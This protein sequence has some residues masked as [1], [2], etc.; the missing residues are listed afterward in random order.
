M[1]YNKPGHHKIA[2][3]IVRG[4][5]TATKTDTQESICMY[6]DEDVVKNNTVTC[7]HSCG[8]FDVWVDTPTFAKITLE[9]H[10]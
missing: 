8:T 4:W 3:E 10:S 9:M 2:V 1:T 5:R 6:C 7:S